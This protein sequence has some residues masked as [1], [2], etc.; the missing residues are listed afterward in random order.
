MDLPASVN[1]RDK[2]FCWAAEEYP[3]LLPVFV[4]ITWLFILKCKTNTHTKPLTHRVFTWGGGGGGGGGYTVGAD[5]LSSADWYHHSII[6]K[7][8]QTN[9]S[10]DDLCSLK[11]KWRKL[12]RENCLKK[13]WWMKCLPKFLTQ[14]HNKKVDCHM[15]LVNLGSKIADGNYRL[16][17]KKNTAAI[18]P[19]CA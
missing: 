2:V 8:I 5:I 13:S 1:T 17:L 10:S 4:M 14:F 18:N 11:K 19:V 9:R 16:T 6:Y 15:S 7:M 3:L 12:K